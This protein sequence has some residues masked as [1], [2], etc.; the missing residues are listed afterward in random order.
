[1]RWRATSTLSPVLVQHKCKNK[2]MCGAEE[3]HDQ[4]LLGQGKHK[5]RGTVKSSEKQRELKR[6]RKHVAV[7]DIEEK[8]RR[9]KTPKS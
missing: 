4:A 1:M 8:H 2:V 7:L 9:V 5:R 6:E 3:R